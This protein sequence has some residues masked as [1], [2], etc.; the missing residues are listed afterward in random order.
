V[1]ADIE[2]CLIGGDVFPADISDVRAGEPQNQLES[3]LYH[4]QAADIPEARIPPADQPFDQQYRNA[5][6]QVEQKGQD[7]QYQSY[8]KG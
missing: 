2:D 7:N 3:S 4:A 6:K 8:H 1:V 5:Q